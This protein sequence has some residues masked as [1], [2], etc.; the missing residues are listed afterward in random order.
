MSTD[1]QIL[2]TQHAMLIC[3]NVSHR[4]RKNIICHVESNLFTFQKSKMYYGFFQCV[5]IHSNP[6]SLD[7]FDPKYHAVYF[8][9]YEKY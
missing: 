2:L 3:S 7:M 1:R 6:R 9:E 8:R 5:L 4:T